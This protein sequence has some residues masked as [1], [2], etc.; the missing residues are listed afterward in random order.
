MIVMGS[1]ITFDI[2]N[3]RTKFAVFGADG[4]MIDAGA[5]CEIANVLNQHEGARVI[6]STVLK[7]VNDHL[8][9][10]LAFSVSLCRDIQILVKNTETLGKDRLAAVM[11]AKFL[12]G[13]QNCLVID[14]GTCITYDYLLGNGDYLGGAISMGI[15]MRYR[16]LNE[17]TSKLPSLNKEEVEGEIDDIGGHTAEAIHSGVCIG[18]FDEVNARIDRFKAKYDNSIVILTGGDANFL[19]K[20]IKYEIFAEPLLVHYGLYHA[21]Q[22]A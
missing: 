5:D 1:V 9:G 7:E 2:G 4:S 8:T 17:F 18:L 15:G 13:S 10:K 19:A 11:G 20:H 3:T 16:A 22:T 12:F 21:I 14:A 6:Y